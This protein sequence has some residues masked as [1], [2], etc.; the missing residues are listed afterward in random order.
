VDESKTVTLTDHDYHMEKLMLALRTS[1]G[2]SNLSTYE[3]YLNPNRKTLIA[4]W[5]QQE[6]VRYD[7]DRLIL[8]HEGMKLSNH[9]ITDLLDFTTSS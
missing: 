4:D 7:N 3:S 2:I 6:L 9:L 5:Q 1:D 8:T